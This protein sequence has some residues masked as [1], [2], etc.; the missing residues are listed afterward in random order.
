MADLRRESV[1]EDVRKYVMTKVFKQIEDWINGT[2]APDGWGS[3]Q[4]GQALAAATFALRPEVCVEI[5]VYG[6][7]SF[8]P[9][10][11]A[12]KEIGHGIAIGIDPWDPAA[13]IIGQKKEDAEWWGSKEMHERVFTN[14]LGYVSQF[15][16]NTFVRIERK[17]SDEVTVPEN[18]GILSI[19]G[20]HGPQA[21]VDIKR[22]TPKVRV[23]GIVYLDD[24]NWHGMAVAT[25]AEW[26]KQNGWIE[27]YGVDNRGAV[28][29]R[30]K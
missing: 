8:L 5:G 29:Q 12:L 10:A 26:M 14:F 2:P 7:R 19:D 1:S 6:G 28:L 11:M 23:G 17:R 16:L 3:V 9:V 27:L 25:G 18:I 20:N 4:L 13:S 30:V 24:L 21:L 22:Y 15:A